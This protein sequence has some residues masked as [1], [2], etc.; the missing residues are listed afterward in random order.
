MYFD[1]FEHLFNWSIVLPATNGISFEISDCKSIRLK[2]ILVPNISWRYCF[3]EFA[4]QARII[5]PLRNSGNE[6]E[7]IETGYSVISC[8][9]SAI[10]TRFLIL[11]HCIL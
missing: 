4:F 3:V 11:M 1:I 7:F 9:S 10:F 2:S 8:V 5:C 6:V